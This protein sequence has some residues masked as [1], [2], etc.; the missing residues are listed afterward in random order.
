MWLRRIG[1]WGF[2]LGLS[3]VILA[4]AFLAWSSRRPFPGVSGTLTVSGLNGPVEVV[5]DG[6]GVPHIYATTPHDLFLAQGFVHAQDRFWQMDTWRHIGAGRLSEMFGESQLETDVFLR[7]MGWYPLAERQ[8]ESSTGESRLLLDAYAEGV[9]QYIGDRSEAMLGLEY[10]VLG[11]INRG[12]EIEPWHPADTLVW[13]KVMAWELRSNLEEEIDRALALGSLTPAELEALYPPYPPDHPLI[14]GANRPHIPGE[15][16]NPAPISG[17]VGLFESANANFESIDVWAPGG[18]SSIGSNSWVVGP[19]MSD[20]G[21]ALLANDP[22]LAIQMPSIWYQNALHCEPKTDACPYS[23]GGFSFAGLPGVIIGHND[24]IAWGFTN[25]APDV[26]DLFIEKINPDNPNQYE[27]EGAWLDMDVRTETI[28]TPAGPIEATIR[29]TH[30][31]PIVS[32]AYGRL[33]DFGT[34]SGI[35]VPSEYALALQWVALEETNSLSTTIRSLNLASNFEEFREALRTFDVPSQNV[36]YA[37]TS[38]NIGYQAPGLI[39]IRQAGNGRSP[40][41]GWTGEYEWTGF[42]SFDDLPTAF[43]PSEGY[44]VTANNPVTDGSFPYLLTTDWNYGHRADRIDQ[45]LR[46]A[47][48]VSPD[49]MASIQNDG[50]DP[51]GEM[52]VPHLMS[53]QTNDDAEKLAIDLVAAWD[54]QTGSDSPAAAIMAATWQ[55]LLANTYADHLPE[56]LAP[57]GGGRWFRVTELI[58]AEPDHWLWDHADTDVREDRDAI[59]SESFSKA[60]AYL[61]D[62][63][64]EN[65]SNW[66]WGEL[67]GATFENQTLGQSGVAPIELLFN[68]GPQAVGGGG[69][70]VTATAWDATNGFGVT[71]VPSMR[72]VIDMGDLDSAIT[73][74]TTGQSGHAFHEHYDDLIEPW[75]NGEYYPMWWERESVIANA[76]STLRLLPAG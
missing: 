50:F 31:G 4:S 72:M 22:H 51:V 67:H 65:P 26:A 35:D 56:E 10:T 37:D 28:V 32:D 49:D 3:L 15:T 46:E 41:P 44:I 14:V 73:V 39:P 55:E 60:V 48:P 59:I 25:L 2:R 71:W 5:R 33:G 63:L 11:L 29:A 23:V 68:R 38:G 27:F 40:V 8:Y 6:A 45:L 58:L 64:G 47:E 74:H 7:T 53:V 12:Y 16:T 18:T 75:A 9:N 30:H 52:L 57:S 70:L 1:K 76:A 43:N 24:D 21:T 54:L 61:V 66:A 13:G 20:T 62:S 19:A 36:V 17:L 42:I 34:Q 69:D